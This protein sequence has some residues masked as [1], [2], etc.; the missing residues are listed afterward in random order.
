MDDLCLMQEMSYE[1]FNFYIESGFKKHQTVVEFPFDEVIKA[2]RLLESGKSVG[3]IV[4][5]V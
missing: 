5:K 3:S 2:Q 4:L 1:L